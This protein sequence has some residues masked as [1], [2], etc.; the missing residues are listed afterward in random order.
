MENNLVT[1]NHDALN[2]IIQAITSGLNRNQIVKYL[3]DKKITMDQD[4][5][6]RYLTEAHNYFNN[7][8]KT[9]KNIHKG[10]AIERLNNLYMNSLK[11][12]DYKACLAIQKEINDLLELYKAVKPS[13]HIHEIPESEIL[14]SFEGK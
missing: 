14:D 9:K 10:I 8:N 1:G 4:S 13:E 12:Q 6:A 3:E 7:A 2:L 5:F 11:I